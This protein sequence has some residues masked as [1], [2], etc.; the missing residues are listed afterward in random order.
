MNNYLPSEIL[1]E[2][3]VVEEVAEEETEEKVDQFGRLM[4]RKVAMIESRR[5]S[6]YFDG[7]K[8]RELKRRQSYNTSPIKPH[9]NPLP[10]L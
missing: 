4:V 7:L 6:K 9:S 2:K 1:A 8:N 10:S 3:E 5:R